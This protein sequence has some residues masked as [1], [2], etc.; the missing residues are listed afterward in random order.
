MHR[1]RKAIALLITVM[2]VMVITVA[3][4]FGLKQVKDASDVL[5]NEAFMY[6]SSIILEDVFKI[7]ESS[8]DLARVGDANSSTE[9]FMLLSSASFIPFESQGISV[10]IK[11]S[12]ARSKF[13]LT[14]LTKENTQAFMEYL[15][16]K[17]INVS[18]VDILLDAQGKIKE[19]KSY[20]SAI[21]EEEPSLFRDYIASESHLE[22]INEFYTKTY[23]DNSLKNAHFENLFSYTQETNASIDLNFATAEVWELLLGAEPQRAVALRQN[24][25]LYTD[26]ESLFLSAEEEERL[27]LFKT[28]FF[29]PFLLVTLEISDEKSS[30]TITFE[31]DIKKKKGSQFVYEI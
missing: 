1:S 21:F 19:D 23:N 6:E 2:F 8:T 15:I 28:S 26:I 5:K 7:L 22:R 24:A 14:S 25:G 17:N 12:S 3:I 29:E 13:P 4:G 9:L 27:A 30:A 10:I 18:Y 16:R 20:N 11:L 31:Y